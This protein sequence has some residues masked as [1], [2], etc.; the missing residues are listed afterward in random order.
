MLCFATG[1]SS[2]WP[3]EDKD[4]FGLHY[5]TK[6]VNYYVIEIKDQNKYKL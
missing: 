3:I 2:S 4:R 1:N 5:K 6:L